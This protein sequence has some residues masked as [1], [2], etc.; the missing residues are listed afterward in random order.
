M[1]EVWTGRSW[2]PLF[3]YRDKG[4]AQLKAHRRQVRTGRRCRVT[5]VL[6]SP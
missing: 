4:H 2:K 3:C 1:L 6:R 5:E